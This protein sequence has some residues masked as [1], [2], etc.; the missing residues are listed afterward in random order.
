MRHGLT[1]HCIGKGLFMPINQQ[2]GVFY[3][4]V[5]EFLIIQ[6]AVKYVD[7]PGKK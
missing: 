1:D 6:R 5:F 4:L 7:G 3:Q 2:F